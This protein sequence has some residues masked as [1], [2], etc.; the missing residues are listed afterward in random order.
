MFIRSSYISILFRKM[1]AVVNTVNDNDE[2]ISNANDPNDESREFTTEHSQI[3]EDDEGKII[4]ITTTDIDDNDEE[5]QKGIAILSRAISM[6][7]DDTLQIQAIKEESERIREAVEKAIENETLDDINDEELE[8]DDSI[9]INKN[10]MPLELNAFE[11]VKLFLTDSKNFFNSSF[12]Q[13]IGAASISSSSMTSPDIQKVVVDT[14]IIF[15]QICKKFKDIESQYGNFFKRDA[16]DTAV[17][18][19][20]MELSDKII[21]SEPYSPYIA[22][23]ILSRIGWG[24]DYFGKITGN[25]EGTER[26]EKYLNTDI[27]FDLKY[28]MNLQRDAESKIKIL[29][30]VKSVQSYS[31]FLS[32]D[33]AK[34]ND[35]NDFIRGFSDIINNASSSLSDILDEDNTGITVNEVLSKSFFETVVR[36]KDVH[37]KS[38]ISMFDSITNGGFEKDRVY[39]FSGKTGGGKS[40]VLLNIAYGMYKVGN[41]LVF[42]EVPILQKFIESD[43]NIR[44]FKQFYKSN[45]NQ[46][47]KDD[48]ERYG[49]EKGQKKHIILYVTLENTEYE[50]VKRF[51]CRMGLVSHIF[52]ML[53]ERDPALCQLVKTK[54]MNFEIQ[55][56]PSL[57]PIELKRR[58]YAIA[59]YIKIVSEN[60]RTEFKVFWRPPYTITT[61]DIFMECKKLERDGYI[62]DAVFVDYPDKMK[63]IDR[64]VS[65]SD[66]SWDTLGKIIDNL[67]GF[68][69]QAGVP[70]IGVS[71]LTRQGNRD[72]GSKSVIIKG[73]STAGSQ[74]KESN[75]DFLI[76]MNIHAKDDTELNIKVDMFK[77][78]Q[79]E[80]NRTKFGAINS[81]FSNQ[82]GAS[83]KANYNNKDDDDT[84]SPERMQFFK[85][86]TMKAERASDILQLS[87]AMPDVQSINNYIVKNRDGTSDIMFDTYIVY[88]M[89]MV[90][91]YD[92]EAVDSAKFCAETFLQI[93]KY[94]NNSH[95]MNQHASQVCNGLQYW[96][97]QKISQIQLQIDDLIRGQSGK[98]LNA[99]PVINNNRNIT[100]FPTNNRSNAPQINKGIPQTPAEM[101]ERFTV[102]KGSC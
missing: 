36:T 14:I 29:D 35:M 12:I 92:Q 88:G 51:M 91:D 52:W 96:F 89:Y 84:I 47:I 85:E 46:L 87:F 6:T 100:S 78:Y 31:K 64:D 17:I 21:N 98:P 56:L 86:V 48:I 32:R 24:M 55:D 5:L 60:S 2:V 79:R 73:G 19:S 61:Y 13:S 43:R 67:K 97:N 90:T 58:L 49:Q 3:I 76:N 53:I 99:V 40:T 45:V 74:Q 15:S 72:S 10:L 33:A 80:I 27:S 30:V 63:P 93:A 20:M 28:A 83:S 62:V 11:Q 102:G 44:I 95:M 16:L 65:K 37:I 23:N 50:T 1:V 8:D 25:K 22:R 39:L 75:T 70:V 77:G 69:K 94:M 18:E 81:L 54:G 38:G 26:F 57:M 82:S 34:C 41:G 7:D 66:Q 9:I 42:P 59:S 4:S 68:S 71:Q 101:F